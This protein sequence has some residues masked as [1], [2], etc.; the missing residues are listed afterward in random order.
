[1]KAFL[2]WLLKVL[3]KP[4]VTPP[5]TP[6][7]TPKPPA[8]PLVRAASPKAWMDWAHREATDGIAEEPNKDNRG[9]RIDHYISLGKCGRPGDPY[10]AI[11]VNAALEQ[12]GVPGTRSA[13][14][15][16]FE[17]HKDFVRLSGPAYGAITTF[18]RGTKSG[19]FGHVGFY[20]G[21]TAHHIYTLGANQGDDCNERPFPID[22]KSF[23][24]VGFYWPKSVPLP[25]IR[26]IEL[27]GRG[28]PVGDIKVT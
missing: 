7:P 13:M 26:K 15:R 3:S 20:V 18:W 25:A 28:R 22:G 2:A 1:M 9:P 11:F 17:H 4:K 16:S 24:L 5:A 6:K 10:C 27:D 8:A 21:Q 23:G 12:A 19:G 14:A